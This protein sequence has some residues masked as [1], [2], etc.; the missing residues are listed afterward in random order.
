MSSETFVLEASGV[1]RE[2]NDLI[3]VDDSLV[4]AYFRVSIRD[5]RGSL[6][7]LHQAPTQRVPLPEGCLAIDLEGVDHLADGLVA[8][9]Q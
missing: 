9:L 1:T 2:G 7:D 6:I 5:L 3:V 4:G 8:L